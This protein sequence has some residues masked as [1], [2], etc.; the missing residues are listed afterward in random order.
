MTFEIIIPIE[1][2]PELRVGATAAEII[3]TNEK[4]ENTLSSETNRVPK[5]AE[6]VPESDEDIKLEKLDEQQSK[7]YNYV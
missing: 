3:L 1:N 5:S 6:E 2:V 7:I 4:T